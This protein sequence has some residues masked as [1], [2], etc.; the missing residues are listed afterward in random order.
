MK[1]GF[2]INSTVFAGTI[3][4]EFIE[5]DGSIVQ[6]EYEDYYSEAAQ[7]NDVGYY[8]LDYYYD[9]D[10]N[11][12][13]V[14]NEEQSQAMQAFEG[15]GT[16][17]DIY[18]I[19]YK[20]TFTVCNMDLTNKLNKEKLINTLNSGAAIMDNVKI[21]P[22]DGNCYL[23]TADGF[24]SAEC[25]DEKE[26]L[27]EAELSLNNVL[28]GFDDVSIQLKQIDKQTCGTD[29]C[30]HGCED[31]KCICPSCWALG[32]DLQ[33]CVPELAN[34]I[35]ECGPTFMELKMKECVL[36]NLDLS[37]AGLSDKSCKAILTE[38][39]DFNGEAYY[40]IRTELDECS[41]D[42]NLDKINK[43]A[44]FSNAFSLSPESENG[45]IKAKTTMF[46]FQCR[47]P[48]TLTAGNDKTVEA[49]TSTQVGFS[50]S[51]QFDYSL[52]FYNDDTFSEIVVDAS[53]TIGETI[54]F[55][56]DAGKA[57]NGLQFSVFDCEVSEDDLSYKILDNRCPDEFV[58][59]FVSSNAGTET[60]QMSYTAF[61]FDQ[62]IMKQVETRLECSI[63]ICNANDFNNACSSTPL[64][65]FSPNF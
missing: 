27:D 57:I 64:C 56:L 40:S 65:G 62:N 47:Y 63:E 19:K 14:Q 42:I 3:I 2:I 36:E 54:Y 4:Q 39:E 55:A 25:T 58:D 23:V 15:S 8:T 16:D 24:Y 26:C 1:L 10:G 46:D 50:G 33:T 11:L 53:V 20:I 43:I 35:M 5:E 12:V 18:H 6:V 51:G 17:E 7:A 21:E 37:N 45:I 30:S 29:Q 60:V 9:E 44:D 13:A 38:G 52:N 61:Q 34:V 31:N 48:T 22:A 59:T 28:F 49:G 32:K 41:T